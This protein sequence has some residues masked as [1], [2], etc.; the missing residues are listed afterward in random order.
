[1]Q[2]HQLIVQTI[3][4]PP[5]KKKKKKKHRMK[6]KEL[7]GLVQCRAQKTQGKPICT[8]T[9]LKPKTIKSKN[10]WLTI[11]INNLY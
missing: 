1:M 7:K 6:C 11:T 9:P 5:K 3:P 2:R 10:I 8:T 4:P